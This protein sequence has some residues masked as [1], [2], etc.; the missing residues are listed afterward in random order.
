MLLLI[1]FFKKIMWL[2]Y[3]D[4]VKDFGI[5]ALFYFSQ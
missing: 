4:I 1:L 2:E 3:K 5:L